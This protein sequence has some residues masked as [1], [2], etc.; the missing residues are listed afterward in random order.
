MA[1]ILWFEY[2]YRYDLSAR[3]RG[4]EY[5]QLR[6]NCLKSADKNGLTC[7]IA[8]TEQK[9]C[10]AARI[11]FKRPQHKNKSRQRVK[12]PESLL[13][14]VGGL[15]ERKLQLVRKSAAIFPEMRT[16]TIFQ[17]VASGTHQRYARLDNEPSRPTH[18]PIAKDAIRAL[19]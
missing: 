14:R 9:P 12:V 15:T 11:S 19:E 10:L 2:L 18:H 7:S 8:D 4:S 17:V 6:L 3:C 16:D 5:V 1:N 13:E